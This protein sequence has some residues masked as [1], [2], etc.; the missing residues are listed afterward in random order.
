MR[1]VLVLLPL[2]LATTPVSA[3]DPCMDEDMTQCEPAERKAFT[4]RGQRDLQAAWAQDASPGDMHLLRLDR[5]AKLAAFVSDPEYRTQYHA[6]DADLDLVPD[7][8]DR[9]PRTPE[10]APTD[11]EGCT[12]SCSAPSRDESRLVTQASCLRARVGR[13]A[14]PVDTGRLAPIEIPL[15]PKCVDADR[16]PSAVSPL[17]WTMVETER[18]PLHPPPVIEYGTYS[19]HEVRVF[20]TRASPRVPGCS[21]FYEFDMR[22]P[23]GS[24]SSTALFNASENR[25]TASPDI[26]TFVIPAYR[27]ELEAM[28]PVVTLI[29][30]SSSPGREKARDGFMG[31]QP[32]HWRVRTVDGLGRSHGWSEWR[33]HSSGPDLSQ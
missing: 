32:V 9:C 7:A 28:P 19:V 6:G 18:G 12:Y 33:V 4:L 11:A 21:L 25:S 10:L 13:A 23:D 27:R 8:R 16:P 17:G 2:L 26:A 15:D 3:Q 5:A 14:R 20:T 30:A 22:F 31:S 29:A 1:C 24:I